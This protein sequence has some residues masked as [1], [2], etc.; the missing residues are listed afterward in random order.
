MLMT[1]VCGLVRPPDRFRTTIFLR[2]TGGYWG[3][4]MI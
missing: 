4:E 1:D 2:I 3:G